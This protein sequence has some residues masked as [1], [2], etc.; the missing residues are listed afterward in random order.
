[1]RQRDAAMMSLLAKSLRPV[2]DTYLT[3]AARRRALNDCRPWNYQ[4]INHAKRNPNNRQ[5]LTNAGWCDDKVSAIEQSLAVKQ[6]GPGYDR[7]L[8][9]TL[10]GASELALLDLRCWTYK[11]EATLK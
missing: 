1:M 10:L 8:K 9:P 6:G 5:N 2:R 3:S 4:K 7:A 11:K